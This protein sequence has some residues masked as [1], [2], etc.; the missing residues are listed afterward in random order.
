VIP[1]F[2]AR[3]MRYYARRA[4][5][6]GDI[7][8]MVYFINRLHSAERCCSFAVAPPGS[9]DAVDMSAVGAAAGG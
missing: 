2:Y 8:G 6:G 3:N 7:P 4:R 1:S 5:E 9:P